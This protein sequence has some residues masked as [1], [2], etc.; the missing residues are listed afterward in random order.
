MHGF[1]IGGIHFFFKGKQQHGKINTYP[2]ITYT[3]IPHDM[4]TYPV[5]QGAHGSGIGLNFIFKNTTK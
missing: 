3:T 5:S 2:L 4:D 1:G